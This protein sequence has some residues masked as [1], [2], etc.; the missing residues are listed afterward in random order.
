[1]ATGGETKIYTTPLVEEALKM[2]MTQALSWQRNFA[3]SR[4]N[5][6]IKGVDYEEQKLEIAQRTKTSRFELMDL[7]E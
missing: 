1:M 3:K 4:N 2:R 7:E 5:C 6:V